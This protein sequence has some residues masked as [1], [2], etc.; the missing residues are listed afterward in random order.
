MVRNKGKD[1]GLMTN[2]PSWPFSRLFIRCA[3]LLRVLKS[4]RIV[5]SGFRQLW[6]GSTDSHDVIQGPSYVLGQTIPLFSG[7]VV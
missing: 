3:H 6:I 1:S 2:E 5:R 4:K 7:G